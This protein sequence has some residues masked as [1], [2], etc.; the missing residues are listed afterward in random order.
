MSLNKL[1]VYEA[2]KNGG[3]VLTLY[4]YELKKPLLEYSDGKRVAIQWSAVKPLL[5]GGIARMIGFSGGYE[6]Y[7]IAP[8]RAC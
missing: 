8:I 1:D 3:R 4:G 7:G 5:K 6:V 2:L